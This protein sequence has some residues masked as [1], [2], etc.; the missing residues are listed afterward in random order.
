MPKAVLFFPHFNNKCF[1]KLCS[2]FQVYCRICSKA[3]ES[4]TFSS[5]PKTLLNKLLV[6]KPPTE[7]Q[8]GAEM[9]QPAVVFVQPG[10]KRAQFNTLPATVSLCFTFSMITPRKLAAEKGQNGPVM[11]RDAIQPF[12][13]II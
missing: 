11:C 9:L 5:K 12:L 8:T 1:A 10:G 6:R 13:L 7:I 4:A 2:N 3:R